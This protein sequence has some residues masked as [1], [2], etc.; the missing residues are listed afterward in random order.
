MKEPFNVLDFLLTYAINTSYDDNNNPEGERYNILKKIDFSSLDFVKGVD[1]LSSLLEIP[2]Y[3]DH[4]ERFKACCLL[5]NQ[6]LSDANFAE[7][8]KKLDK[9]SVDQVVLGFDVPDSELRSIAVAARLLNISEMRL[10]QDQINAAIVQVQRLTADP[11]T[12]EKLGQ[13]GY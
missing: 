9:L 3:V 4:L 8:K 5:I 7:K 13:V 6:K 2:Q 1:D 11:K 10:L 12:N